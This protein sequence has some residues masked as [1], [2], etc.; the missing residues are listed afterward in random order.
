MNQTPTKELKLSAFKYPI[1]L[2]SALFVGLVFFSVH[3]EKPRQFKA[4]AVQES[5]EP[6]S[7]PE[8]FPDV[9]VA[10][11]ESQKPTE[12]N[13]SN[14]NSGVA[15]TNKTNESNQ[16]NTNLVIAY[17]NNDAGG[18]IVLTRSR[19]EKTKGLV[20]YTTAQDGKIDFG[21]WTHDE[22]FILINWD[23]EGLN[24][25]TYDRF[26]DL[27]SG[28]ILNPKNL[29]DGIKESSLNTTTATP[30]TKPLTSANQ[31]LDKR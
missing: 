11:K 15:S 30:V 9:D 20:A 3:T 22:L 12:T 8:L 10:K 21:C 23:K 24:N 29:S 18:K 13:K 26:F 1:Y 5:N 14:T 25:Y 28:K 6:K 7:F 27:G 4:K 31:M 17:S 19:C 2:S 16:S